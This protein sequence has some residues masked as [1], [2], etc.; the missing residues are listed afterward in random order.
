MYPGV[1]AVPGIDGS[2][3]GNDLFTMAAAP[4]S[5]TNSRLQPI[6]ARRVQ[7]SDEDV[8]A[9]RE[10]VQRLEN[11]A[12]GRVIADNEA[13]FRGSFC[14]GRRKWI[15][16][17]ASI[18]VVTGIILGIV[19]PMLQP[20]ETTHPG[21]WQEQNLEDILSSVS[22]DGGK[23]LRTPWTPQNQAY[24]WL[25]EDP[26]LSL[27]SNQTKI[28]RYALATMYYSTN[29]DNWTNNAGWLGHGNEC[30]WYSTLDGASCSNGSMMYLH[31]RSNNLA[32]TIPEE[33]GILSNLLGMC[34]LSVRSGL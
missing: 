31:E 18:L 3:S 23:A 30:D 34:I 4:A 24:N 16:I 12:V 14:H 8:Q 11:T 10:A 25:L 28:Q 21:E 29:G 27:Y 1:V 19:S 32:G 22:F 5:H 9:L 6:T 20:A 7:Y 2:E 13:A 33:I 26:N 17:V 15:T